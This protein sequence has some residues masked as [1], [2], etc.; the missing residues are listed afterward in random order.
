MISLWQNPFCSTLEL[1]KRSGPKLMAVLIFGICA[2]AAISAQSEKIDQ[3]I[4]AEM[5]VR[6]IPGLAL[7]VIKNGE[8]V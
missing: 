6:H 1:L 2:N 8:I 7:V 5:E 3:Y 4:R